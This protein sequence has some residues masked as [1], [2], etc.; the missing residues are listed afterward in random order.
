MKEIPEKRVVGPF[1]GKN[2]PY[3]LVIKPKNKGS[4]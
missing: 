3:I 4:A 1:S 2:A